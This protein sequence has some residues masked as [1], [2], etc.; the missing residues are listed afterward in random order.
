[1][2]HSADSRARPFLALLTALVAVSCSDSV[3]PVAPNGVPRPAAS[4]ASQAAT[5]WTVVATPNP[6]TSSDDLSAVRALSSTDVWAVGYK[7]S[8]TG[9]ETLAEHMTGSAWSVTPSPNPG[10]S[11]QCGS[12]NV[13]FDVAGS[14]A[15]NLWA[16]GYYY[17]CSLFKPLAMKWNG[18]QWTVYSTPIPGTSGNNILNAVAVT[19]TGDAWAVGY[20]EANNGAPTPLILRS[21]GTSW[22]QVTGATVPGATSNVLNTVAVAGPNDVW[23]AGTY[24]DPPTGLTETMVQHWNGSAWSIVPSPSPGNYLA[25]VI[26]QLVAV[27]PSDIWAFGYFDDN[28][29]GRVTLIEHWNGSAWSIVPSPNGSLSYFSANELN[30]AVALSANDIWAVGHWRSGPTNQQKQT[31]T[32]H[33]DGSAWTISP[34]PVRGMASNLNSIATGGG[35]LWAVGEFSQYGNDQYTGAF[36]VP[37]TLAMKQ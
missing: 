12:G 25:N 30:G 8:S 19:S 24:Y 23:A 31:L 35:A 9:T 36:I 2:T 6:S 17:S 37:R 21:R 4:A 11:N 5:G 18:S 29:T 26:N 32:L 14:S 27:S 34:S 10:A 13:L 33:W 3:T 20:Y 22:T 15:T 28:V 7:G 1:M 16:V